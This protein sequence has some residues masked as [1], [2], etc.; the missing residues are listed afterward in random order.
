VDHADQPGE[1]GVSEE[2]FRTP[3]ERAESSWRDSDTRFRRFADAMPQLVW[4]ARPDGRIDYH[5]QRVEELS[6]FARRDDGTFSWEGT[7]HDEDLGYTIEAWQRAVEEARTYEVTHRLKRADGTTH[8]Y[9]TRAVPVLDGEGRVA[10]WFGTTTDIDAQKRSEEALREADGHKN[11]F[12]AMLSH[13]LRNPFNVI[14]TSLALLQQAGADSAHGKRALTVLGRQVNLIGRLLDDLLDVTRISKGKLVLKRE[15]VE[16]NALV[17]AIG[18]D[19]AALFERDRIGF[20]VIVPPRPLRARVDTARLTQAIGN[21][22]QNA[23]KFTPEGGR[24]TLSL[25]A[26]DGAD[27]LIEVSDDGAGV[28]PELIARLFDPFV[29]A[30]R[31]LHQS[32][33]G[34]GLGLAVVKGIVELHGGV[35]TAA[36]DG[37]GRG[38]VFT[39]RLPLEGEASG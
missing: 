28:Q 23:A 21:L 12:L 33:G 10:E 36:S 24:A 30:D 20:G 3:A 34:L 31:T 5:N 16:L 29:Q 26:N 15:S 39:I 18:E 4:T 7:V 13:D 27:A 22:L 6:G 38:A 14:R 32:R 35:V 17:R 2:R 25:R 1:R 19:H 11:E 9:L 37:P 8:W